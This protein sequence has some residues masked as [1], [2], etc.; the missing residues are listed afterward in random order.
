MVPAQGGEVILSGR[1]ARHLAV[2]RRA[3]LGDRITI[4]DGRGRVVEARLISVSPAVVHAEVDASATWAPPQPRVHVL[5]G[6]AKGDKVDSVVRQ[7]VELGVDAITVFGAGRSVARWDERQSATAA[8]RWAAVAHEAAKQ[9]RRRWLP[10]LAGPVGL[11]AAVAGVGPGVGPG[12]GLIAHPGNA[13]RLRDALPGPEA[14]LPACVW[15]VVGPEGGLTDAEVAA[16]REA[17]GREVS[18]GEQILRTETAGVVIAAIVLH[19]YGR[20]G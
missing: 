11:A 15:V 6:L 2:V 1:D 7:L 20:I 13:P 9:S 16:F 4:G 18:L 5:Q 8:Q 14:P 12:V 10:T 19:I 17:G 3:Q